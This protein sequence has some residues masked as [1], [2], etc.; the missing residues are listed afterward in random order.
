MD[1][2]YFHLTKSYCGYVQPRWMIFS[3]HTC[4]ATK[5]TINEAR[6]WCR[7]HQAEYRPIM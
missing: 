5:R 2:L 4:L 7:E 3:G 1:Y 6:Q